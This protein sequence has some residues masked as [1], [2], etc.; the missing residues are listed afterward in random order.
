V[1]VLVL[2]IGVL[3]EGAMFSFKP[4]LLAVPRAAG[5]MLTI[6]GVTHG[7]QSLVALRVF[8]AKLVL[9]RPRLPPAV[10]SKGQR[11]RNQQSREGQDGKGDFL[12]VGMHEMAPWSIGKFAPTPASGS[13][14]RTHCPSCAATL[15]PEHALESAGEE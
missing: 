11:S 15:E 5:V 12:Q 9:D 4:A 2:N 6:G 7:V 8:L 10:M 1:I 13:G 3:T 14:E